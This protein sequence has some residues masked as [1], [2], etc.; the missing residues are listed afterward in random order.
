MI[1]GENRNFPNWL[2][3]FV[4]SLAEKDN[5]SKEITTEAAV[6]INDLPKVVWNDE[7]FFI[8]FDPEINAATILNEFGNVVTTI[9][10]ATTVDDV[11]KALN[12]K[13][14]IVS[15]K[16]N[17][18]DDVFA[19]ELDKISMYLDHQEDDEK[20]DNDYENQNVVS[21]TNDNMQNEASNVEFDMIEIEEIEE[22]K[23]DEKDKEISIVENIDNYEDSIDSLDIEDIE[24]TEDIEE[25]KCY[26][27]DIKND[28]NILYEKIDNLELIIDKMMND[29]NNCNP[30][31]NNFNSE[32]DQVEY[33]SDGTE[34]IIVI[35][36]EGIDEDKFKTASC[37]SCENELLKTKIVK[38]FQGIKCSGGC[39]SEYAVNLKSGEIFKKT[40]S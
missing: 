9:Q 29:N 24:D 8:M 26:N 2:N 32:D 30:P 16:E 1:I 14:V 6:N 33:I 22:V 25:E 40:L 23:E 13:Q 20:N 15:K 18:L 27:E 12:S 34:D 5:L 36:L 38:G 28:I 19:Q 4:N 17:K 35:K 37:P 7:K 39:G 31:L 11:D 21:G 10:N 3:D